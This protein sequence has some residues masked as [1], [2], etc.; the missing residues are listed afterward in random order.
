[1]LY[2]L[3]GIL[4]IF[5]AVIL[6]RAAT[7]KPYPHPELTNEDINI[8]RERAIQNM[9][10]MIKCKTVS[11]KDTSLVDFKEFEKFQYLLKE[12]YPLIHKIA[13]LTKISDTGLLYYIKGKS[14]DSPSVCMSHYDVVPVNEEGWDKPAFEGIIENNTIWGR[15]TLDTKGT[16][17][18]IMEATEQLLSNGF[19]PENDLY[20]SFAG[21]EETTGKSCLEIVKYLKEKNI[22]PEFVIDEGG[23]V[24]DNVFPGVTSSCALIGI[25][26][27]G[28][29]DI[30]LTLK[31]QG[32]HAS[33]PPKNTILGELSKAV[34][35]VEKKPFKSQF[36]KPVK[37]MFD[38]L[39]RHSSFAFKILFANLW[40]FLPIL[41]IVC[42]ASGGELNAMM[43]TTC[44]I[45]MMEGS[46]AYNVL[47][48]SASI[49]MNLRLMGSDTPKSAKSYLKKIINNSKIDIEIVNGDNPSISSNTNCEQWDT[50]KGVIHNVWPNAIVSPYLM[51]ACSDSRS[52]CKI[53]DKVYRFSAMALTKEERGM[54]HAHNERIPIDSLIKTVEFYYRLIKKL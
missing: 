52:Y 42:K 41:K 1:M 50:L 24:V 34:V 16:L 14:S 49:G 2:F 22:K 40:C 10:D 53:S 38:T 26:E 13:S 5:L 4:V 11:Y 47:P 7:F 46:K 37:E 19:M 33:T 21:D 9:V 12:R 31:S 17:C 15:G 18:G 3:L 35:A 6:I 25:A 23:A 29:C 44:A 27:K 45:T 8:N 20:L 32:G 51:M 43:R 54:I 48:P 36:T 39:G 28:L 30:R